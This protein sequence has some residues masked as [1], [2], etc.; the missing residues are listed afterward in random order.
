ML[1]VRGTKPLES[2]QLLNDLYSLAWP[3]ATAP[4]SRDAG[5]SPRPGESP[6]ETCATCHFYMTSSERMGMPHS[7]DVSALCCR[8][9]VHWESASL[10][11][12][13]NSTANR[14]TPRLL[15]IYSWL[16]IVGV[17]AVPQP[18][19]YRT[20]AVILRRHDYGEADRILTLYTPA[21]GKLRAI[22]KGVRRITSRKAGHVE[23]LVRAKLLLAR[24]RELDVLTQAETIDAYI[25]LR[26]DLYLT[27]CGYFIAELVDRSVADRI[28]NPPLYQLLVS[29]LERLASGGRAD[30]TL[31]FFEL[32]LLSFI[33]YAP[34]LRR[35]VICS[36]E[37][38]P[39]AHAF[40][41]SQ[42]GTMCTGCAHRLPGV[43]ALSLNGLKALRWLSQDDYD[44]VSRLRLT[45]DLSDELERILHAQLR[46]V[47]ETEIKSASFVNL[48]RG[49]KT[50]NPDA[51]GVLA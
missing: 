17:S 6:S 3:Q 35:C 26:D 1:A 7:L 27:A 32:H 23:L 39:D 29:S 22:A 8:V 42:G 30:L 19:T 48:V 47:L 40:A 49:L 12:E 21:F 10:E 38:R 16:S 28:E 31:R 11:A 20:E 24:G 5:T 25:S 46:Y 2:E 13:G 51:R 18:R 50:I 14:R 43:L 44:A 36:N 4:Y 33:G 15:F 37:I 41:P 9:N 34:E 45:Q